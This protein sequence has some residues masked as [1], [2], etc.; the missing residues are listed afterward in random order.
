MLVLY[1]GPSSSHLLDLKFSRRLGPHSEVL[2]HEGYADSRLGRLLGARGVAIRFGG[3]LGGIR[4]ESFGGSVGVVGFEGD[5]FLWEFVVELLPFREVHVRLRP[6]FMDFGV[7]G[8]LVVVA[9]EVELGDVSC[10]ICGRR[11]GRIEG[12][13]GLIYCGKCWAKEG[14]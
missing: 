13:D 12:G 6:G 9:D 14:R 10:S 3:G 8:K 11:P 4:A 7:L 5:P 1:V 2:W